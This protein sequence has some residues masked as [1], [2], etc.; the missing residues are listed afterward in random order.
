MGRVASLDNAVADSF[1][2]TLKTEFV[3]RRAFTTRTR[4]RERQL[5]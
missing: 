3:H 2:S 5:S 1:N 4:A